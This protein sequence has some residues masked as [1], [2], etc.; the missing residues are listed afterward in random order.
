MAFCAAI[1]TAV[2]VS[3]CGSGMPG[4]A[5]VQIGSATISMAALDHWT[6]VANDGSQLQS[7]TKASP[8]PIPP[9][10]TACI[11]G[12]EKTAGNTAASKTPVAV[13]SDKATCESDFEGTLMP[14]VLNYL[15]PRMWIQGEAYDRGIHVTQKQVDNSFALARKNTSSPSLSTAADL[16]AFEA[17]SGETL[18]DLRWDTLVQL[19]TDKV[20]LQVEKKADKI[21]EAA[22]ASYYAKH[23][24]LY[25][26]PET[27]NIH[28]VLVSSLATANK[29]RSLL[30]G[31]ESYAVVAKAYSTDPT[32]KAA[33]GAMVG[34]TTSE[35]TAA[36]SAKVFAAA[37]GVLSG[38]VKTAFGYYVFTVDKVVP[39]QK[40]TFAKA[41]ASIKTALQQKAVT[42]AENAL[43]T[44]FTK[45]WAPR[46]VCRS[47][48]QVATYCSNPPKSGSTS[49]TGAT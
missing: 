25:V 15:I 33:G 28:L 18:Q 30:A 37:V 27:R 5:V 11:A 45:K 35:L 21:S 6:V 17:A 10:Y 32:S 38:P 22:I 12:Q 4:N 36:L 44:N 40:E 2:T 39:S 43:Q 7:G 23:Q 34:V 31:G 16:R 8:A 14:E 49:A 47:G 24:S 20:E 42:A 3:A 29:V 48:Y 46:T 1:A 26:T 41:K 9:D 19:E 13:A